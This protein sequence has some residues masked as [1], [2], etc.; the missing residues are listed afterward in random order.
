M[1]ALRNIGEALTC[2]I[3]MDLVTEPICMPCPHTMCKECA[4]DCVRKMSVVIS[5]FPCPLCKTEM[6]LARS[7]DAEAVEDGI[8]GQAYKRLGMSVP[9]K[10]QKATL[11][12]ALKTFA[13]NGHDV[14]QCSTI[15]HQRRALMII[16]LQMQVTEGAVSPDLVAD[17]AATV[18]FETDTTLQLIVDEVLRSGALKLLRPVTPP[19]RQPAVDSPRDDARAL[20]PIP[21]GSFGRAPPPFGAA[22][23]AFGAV[24]STLDPAPVSRNLSSR[25]SQS[26]SRGRRRRSR[27]RSRRRRRRSRSRSRGRRGNRYW[28][29]HRRAGRDQSPCPPSP[30]RYSP[31]ESSAATAP[32]TI[33]WPPPRSTQYVQPRLPVRSV[34]YYDSLGFPHFINL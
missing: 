15:A 14:P 3:C 9:Q 10:F 8:L 19:D 23:P 17:L 24:L 6:D 28:D 18:I 1:L 21:L 7:A 4:R 13:E 30:R 34:K 5:A 25:R 33:F 22:P 20:M 2:P 31:S 29:D 27:S 26:Q 11:T 16:E 32:Q 12:S